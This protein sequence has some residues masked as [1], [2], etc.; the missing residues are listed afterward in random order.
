MLRFIGLL[1][2]AVTVGTGFNFWVQGPMSVA[3]IL[4]VV[5]AFMSLCLYATRE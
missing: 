5:A 3:I 4:W 1:A 2:V